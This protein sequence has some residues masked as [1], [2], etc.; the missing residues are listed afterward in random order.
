MLVLLIEGTDVAG[1]VAHGLSLATGALLQV[2]L[3]FIVARS[4]MWL[5]ELVPDVCAPATS[6]SGN[7][8]PA[9]AFSLQDLQVMLWLVLLVPTHRIL[10]DLV[11]VCKAFVD[12]RKVD[13]E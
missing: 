1:S 5:Q 10:Q 13:R 8:L 6:S 3:V 9:V 11:Q 7:K 4:Q 2:V 12:L